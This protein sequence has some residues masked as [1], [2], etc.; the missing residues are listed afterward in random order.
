MKDLTLALFKVCVPSSVPACGV[1][2]HSVWAMCSTVKRLPFL[3]HET[4]GW[5]LALVPCVVPNVLG[6]VAWFPFCVL[7]PCTDIARASFW[8]MG[9]ESRVALAAW[10]TKALIRNH[11][12]PRGHVELPMGVCHSNEH[13]VLMPRRSVA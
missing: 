12:V 6:V 10:R 3:W 2:P 11:G 8:L 9:W 5:Q 7:G 13:V 4:R 1:A